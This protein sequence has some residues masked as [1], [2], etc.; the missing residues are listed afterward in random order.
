MLIFFKD[1]SSVMEDAVK[2][3]LWTLVESGLVCVGAATPRRMI[4]K[5]T[6]RNGSGT[7]TGTSGFLGM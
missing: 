6:K 5:D 2:L 7:G 4:R 3:G 1:R